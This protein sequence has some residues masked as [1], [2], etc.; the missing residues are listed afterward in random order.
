MGTEYNWHNIIFCSYSIPF[1]LIVIVPL[2]QNFV[3]YAW[4]LTKLIC[5]PK[6]L[7]CDR[8]C[9]T[10]QRIRGR[11]RYV[12]IFVLVK[13]GDIDFRDHEKYTFPRK[14]QNQSIRVLIVDICFENASAQKALWCYIDR[15]VILA[16]IYVIILFGQ[17]KISVI[18][19]CSSHI[20]GLLK[21][22]HFKRPVYYASTW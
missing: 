22:R 20:F 6:N 19:T 17:Y 15:T 18:V 2:W 1:P 8:L 10:I 3:S 9:V 16:W 11:A 14:T 12:P 5:C 13:T 4:N 21:L 7:M